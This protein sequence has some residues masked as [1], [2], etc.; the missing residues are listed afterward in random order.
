MERISIKYI[1]VDRITK[2]TRIKMCIVE[3]EILEAGYK[4]IEAGLIV[5]SDKTTRT[6]K[7]RP[8]NIG[9]VVLYEDST[10]IRAL[11]TK[12]IDAIKFAKKYVK[13]T[14]LDCGE[15]KRVDRNGNS[16]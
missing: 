8:Y 13:G 15:L 12:E 3:K 16:Y 11:R 2:Q 6:A 4:K 10:I 5:K 14:C 1:T 9:Y 7:V